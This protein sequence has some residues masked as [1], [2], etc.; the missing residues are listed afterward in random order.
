[1]HKSVL[2]EE[3]IRALDVHDGDTVVDCTFGAG[4][5]SRELLSQHRGNI[6]LIVIDQDEDALREGAAK[7]G[8]E[9][10]SLTL[11]EGNFGNIRAL[12]E[13]QGI[14]AV[15][16]VV[17]DLGFSSTQLESSGRGFSFKRDEPLLMTYQT[18]PH[19]EVLT[20]RE[21]VNTWDEENLEAIL[22]GFG[23]ERRSKKI[24]R[25]IVEA[26]TKKP[27][28]SAS[29]LAT[30]VENAVGMRGRIH[31]GTKTFQALR[32]VVNDELSNLKKALNDS[33]SLLTSS[34]RIAVIS[35]HSLE[36][37]IVKQFIKEKVKEQTGLA[38][39]KKPLRPTQ[40]EIKENP[41]SRSAKLRAVEKNYD[42]K[43]T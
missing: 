24:A 41:R 8:R 18:N 2:L 16:R 40:L 15:D 19:D 43:N 37:R 7:L 32:I 4:G 13:K 38:I 31:P 20:A 34:G 30:I 27:I 23:E 39:T 35:F 3:T 9:F 5:L 11:L 1:M 26:R 12:L 36:D 42:N 21:V 14:Q 22:R 6:K 28:M 10:P 17:F 25:A 29:E 33:F